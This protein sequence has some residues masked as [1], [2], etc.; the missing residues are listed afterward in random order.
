ML[1]ISP[2]TRIF[3]ALEPVDMRAG[4]NRLYAL[5]ETR[6]NQNP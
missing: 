3:V 2:T 4:F 5:V 6:L 1:S